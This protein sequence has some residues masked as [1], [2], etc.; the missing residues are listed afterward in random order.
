MLRIKNR[1]QYIGH[2]WATWNIYSLWNENI[3]R[4]ASHEG[5][6]FQGIEEDKE[7]DQEK[8]KPGCNCSDDSYE[9][10]EMANFVRKLKKWID[11]YK[12]MLPLKCFNCGGIGHFSSKC[13]HKNKNNKE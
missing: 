5:R 12:G 1:S 3:T 9:D 10:E 13:T 7:E 11:K 8:V 6:K 4:E 2:G